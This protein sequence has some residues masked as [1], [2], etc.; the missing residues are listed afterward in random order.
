MQLFFLKCSINQ[1]QNIS[2]ETENPDFEGS[3]LQVG[4]RSSYAVLFQ[5]WLL[6]ETETKKCQNSLFVN[7]RES[8]G[9]CAF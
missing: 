9:N 2:P 7:C 1:F 3:N 8:H 4:P 5:L 6:S